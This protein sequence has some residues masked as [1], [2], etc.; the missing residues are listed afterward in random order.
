[1]D[2]SSNQLLIPTLPYVSK[3]KKDLINVIEYY[4]NYGWTTFSG[5]KKISKYGICVMEEIAD[6]LINDMN[7]KSLKEAD[8]ILVYGLGELDK[9]GLRDRAL[10]QNQSFHGNLDAFWG[11]GTFDGEI[12]EN[13]PSSYSSFR[14]SEKDLEEYA[15]NLS[16]TII[17]AY[18]HIKS[19]FNSSEDDKPFHTL[20]NSLVSGK[21]VNVTQ[22]IAIN[23]YLRAIDF[24]AKSACKIYDIFGRYGFEDLNA[25]E[26]KN[27]SMGTKSEIFSKRNLKVMNKLDESLSFFVAN[28]DKTMLT[29]IQY[30]RKKA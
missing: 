15:K 4:L 7:E 21:D 17:K 13:K 16:E 26:F 1:M 19:G 10:S 2:S 24:A 8:R 23:D 5:K 25:L 6:F 30:W 14:L 28:H 27:A 22:T 11:I 18:P 3:A 9:Y 29:M 12:D 20:T